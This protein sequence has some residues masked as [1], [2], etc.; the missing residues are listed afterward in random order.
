MTISYKL[1]SIINIMETVFEFNYIGLDDY[2]KTILNKFK[3][4]IEEFIFTAY[5]LNINE[6]EIIIRIEV[7]NKVSKLIHH[8]SSFLL[9]YF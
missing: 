6:V 4:R 2:N 9:F 1:V 3:S 8:R 5:F 7:S